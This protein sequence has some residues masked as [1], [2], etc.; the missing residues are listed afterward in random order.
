M[1]VT[2]DSSVLVA[3]HISRAGVCAAL[4]E[5]VL[6]GHDLVLSEFI[7]GELRE[8]LSG[9][10][11]YPDA[12][13]SESVFHLR[14]AGVVVQPESVPPDACRDPADLAIL[15]TAI[16]GRCDLLISVDKDLLEIGVYREVVIV[17]PGEFWR[18]VRAEGQ[19]S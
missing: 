11:G 12:V 13:C 5:D 9:K 14:R 1:R 4:L 3:A 15:G 10:F 16:A 6:L 17:K 2:L 7:L 18:R 8:K 19:K